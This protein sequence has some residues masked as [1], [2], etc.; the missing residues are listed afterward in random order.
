M[1]MFSIIGAVAVLCVV[2][3][4]KVSAQMTDALAR[5]ADTVRNVAATVSLNGTYSAGTIDRTLIL[6]GVDVAAIGRLFG[7]TSSTSFTYGTFGTYV[8][9]RD[10]LTKNFFFVA[11]QERWYPFVMVWYERGLRRAIEHRLQPALGGTWVALQDTIGWIRLSASMAPEF[12]DFRSPLPDGRSSITVYRAIGRVAAWIRTSD[13]R[14]A[15]DLECWVQPNVEDLSDVRA[16]ANVS[17]SVK[18]VDELRLRANTTWIREPYVPSTV[19]PEDL[20]ITFGLSY[21]L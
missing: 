11:P 2:G 15:A 17:F 19:Q 5:L 1:R 14:F 18:I 8:T 10:L 9:E 7:V 12:T 16:Y 4:S 13:H 20:L 6:A 21:T 3:N